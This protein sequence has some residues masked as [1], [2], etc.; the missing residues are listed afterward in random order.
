MSYFWTYITLTG[1]FL[2][3]FVFASIFHTGGRGE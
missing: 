2:A 3:G 1:V